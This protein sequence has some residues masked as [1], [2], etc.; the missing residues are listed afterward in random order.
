[1][2]DK[3]NLYLILHNIRSL[4]NLGAILRTAEGAGADKVFL[5]GYTPSSIDRF[6][7]MKKQVAKT[8]LG[9]EKSIA[10]EKFANIF[11]LVE[12]LKKE[13]IFII[14]LEQNPGAISYKKFA[15]RYCQKIK[16]KSGL[17]LILGNEI[18]GLSQN[19]LKESDAIIE[20]PMFGKKDSLN[21]S[22]AAG[23]ALFELCELF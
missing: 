15:S 8:A 1:M 19:I 23:I 22:V 7:R 20:I 18:Q 11:R 16:N 3:K 17:V 21:V 10:F 2:G 6:G 4:Y 5:T 12:I 9:A 13:K 14:A